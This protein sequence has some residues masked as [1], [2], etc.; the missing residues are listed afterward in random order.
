MQTKYKYTVIRK[1]FLQFCRKNNV[2]PE[3]MLAYCEGKLSNFPNWYVDYINYV[4]AEIRN[5]IK[6]GTIKKLDLSEVWGG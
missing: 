1:R 3:D 2:S 5:R 4:R 6:T